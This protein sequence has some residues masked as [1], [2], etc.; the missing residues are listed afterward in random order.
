MTETVKQN[1]P[2]R[3]AGVKQKIMPIVRVLYFPSRNPNKYLRW[4][5]NVGKVVAHLVVVLLLFIGMVYVGLFGHIPTHEELRN[6][7][8]VEASEVYSA[9]QKLLGRYYRQNR[10]SV[11]SCDI[12]R[13]VV[14]AL[15]ATED[16]RFFEHKGVDVVSVGRVIVR[17]LLMFDFSQG[18]GSTLSQQ[19]A[20][21]LYPRNNMWF[22]TYPVAKVKEIIIAQRLEDV[23]S[24]DEILTLYLNT[25]PFGENLYG[26]EAASQRFFSRRAK[27]LEPHQAATLVGMLAANTKYNPRLNPELS[28]E[29]RN[30]VLRRMQTAG[31]LD[32]VQ[33][34][35]YQAKELGLKYKKE[36][37]EAGSG[38]Y[39]RSIV[40]IEAQNILND[41]YGEKHYNIY[42]D[43]LIINTTINSRLQTYAEHAV[44][45]HMT[46]VQNAFDKQWK[47]RDPWG[48]TTSIYTRAY[49]QSERYRAMVKAGLPEDTI[50]AVMNRPVDMLVYNAKGVEEVRMSPADSVRKAVTVLNAGFLAINPHNGDVLAWVGGINY[51]H[52]QIDHVSMRRQVGSTFKPIVY[53]TA[54]EHGVDPCT[55]VE[56]VRRTYPAHDD[57]SPGNSDGKYGGWYSLKGALSKSL[58]TVSAWL[59][60]EVGPSNVVAMARRMGIESNVPEVASIALG[61]AEITLCEMVRAYGAFA[62]GGCVRNQTMITSIKD[63]DGNVLYESTRDM[64]GAYV[65]SEV[66][67]IY[68]NDM[69]KAVVDSGTARSLRNVYKLQGEVAGKTGTTQNGAD[70]WFI[71]MMP[72]IVAG[73]WVG[74]DNP[75]IRFRTGY[76]GQGAYMALPIVGRVFDRASRAN[77]ETYVGGQFPEPVDDDMRL[78]MQYPLS[79][80]WE[81]DMDSLY[82][83]VRREVIDGEFDGMFDREPRARPIKSIFDFMRS[84]FN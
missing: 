25:V 3:W 51:T 52:S 50:E 19:L 69:M 6:I 26:I 5:I 80:A 1:V 49:K 41:L 44:A 45:S 81:P 39:F 83:A 58:N 36:D 32:S 11:D 13:H 34:Q 23:Y 37:N 61:T 18:G 33:M 79:L 29:R 78:N 72:G 20:K 53:A 40:G 10:I 2:D 24:K 7:D 59:I 73:A 63:R 71:G 70:G 65:M 55:Y 12:S 28:L 27:R 46:T 42:T 74:C 84:L 57:W 8:N 9:D 14:N 21:N 31:F 30:L 43:G 75:S 60:N 68:V 47:G 54:L 62:T 66:T 64:S 15:V 22:L 76:Y 48:K 38:M 77:M 16:S 82:Y 17:T 67:A 56:N 4:T 35:T